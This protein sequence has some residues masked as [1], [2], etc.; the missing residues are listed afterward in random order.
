VENQNI[1]I[2]DISVELQKLASSGLFTQ[3]TADACAQAASLLERIREAVLTG[4]SE[5]WHTP[6][7]SAMKEIVEKL[8]KILAE[9]GEG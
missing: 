3:H 7:P 8:K 2:A 5:N 9:Q 6:G 1:E 4:L